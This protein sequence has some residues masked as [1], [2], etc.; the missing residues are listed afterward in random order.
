MVSDES[1]NNN[2]K[3]DPIANK[4]IYGKKILAYQKLTANQ[5]N[6]ILS[7][8]GTVYDVKFSDE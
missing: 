7:D 2:S 4:G 8:T 5:V 3:L 1:T 6:S